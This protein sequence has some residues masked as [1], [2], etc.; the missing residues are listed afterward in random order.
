[1][2][3]IGNT[4]KL[5]VSFKN[6][7]GAAADPEDGTITMRLYD[8]NKGL[9]DEVDVTLADRT[10]VGAYTVYYTLPGGPDPVTVEFRGEDA[11]GRP[12]V[13]REWLERAWV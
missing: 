5:S 4:I 7:E 8:I 11:Q 6:W 9:I 2:A 3:T 10:G 1:M 13:I 12:I